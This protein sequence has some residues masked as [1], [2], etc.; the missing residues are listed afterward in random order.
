[1]RWQDDCVL[2]HLDP[3]EASGMGTA[4]PLNH[5]ADPGAAAKGR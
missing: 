4:A 2:E 1:M 3:D 5:H